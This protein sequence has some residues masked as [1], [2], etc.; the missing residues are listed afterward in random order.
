MNR[1]FV[2]ADVPDGLLVVTGE[3]DGDLPSF[4]SGADCF[5]FFRCGLDDVDDDNSSVGGDASAFRLAFLGG[6]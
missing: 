5:C 1:C 6:L 4:P 2:K 3:V